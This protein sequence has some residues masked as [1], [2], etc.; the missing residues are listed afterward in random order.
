MNSHA[1]ATQPLH[2]ASLDSVS[3]QI[4]EGG[5]ARTL[6][7][8]VNAHF[9]AGTLTAIMGPSGSGKSTLLSILGG[10][11]APTSGR[12]VANGVDLTH[13]D[14]TARCRFRREH[15]GFVFQDIRLLPQLNALDN[16]L[17]PAW[18]RFADADRARKVANDAMAAVGMMAMANAMPSAMSGGEKQRVAL[19]RVLA[20]DP[21]LILADEPTAALDW[22]SAET[23]L[24]LLRER[25]RGSRKAAVLVTHDPRVIAWVQHIY[26]L[27][28]GML[29]YEAHE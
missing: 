19:A 2:L 26:H 28:D 3:H 6:F 8:N 22:A 14:E 5:S 16:V 24:N 23:F 7:E 9:C 15:V 20:C 10:L 25:V 1:H 18:F 11:V 29:R 13:L 4:T 21:P 17:Y 12:V 27:E